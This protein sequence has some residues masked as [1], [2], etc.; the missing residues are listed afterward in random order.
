LQKAPEFLWRGLVGAV[1]AVT[2]LAGVG[3]VLLVLLTIWLVWANRTPREPWPPVLALFVGAPIFLFLIDIRRSGLGIDAAAAPRYS[4][5]VLA[6]L[7]PAA[8]LAATSLFA[9]RP[10]RVVLILGGTALLCVVGVSELNDQARIY[11]PFKQENE[12]RIIA[13]A[14]LVRSDATLLTNQPAPEFSPE[15]RVDSLR[16]L[17]RD[18]NLPDNVHV[19]EADRLTAASFLQVTVGT[20]PAANATGEPT[21]EGAE[22]ARVTSSNSGSCIVVTPR[23]DVPTVLLSFAEPGT[24]NVTPSRSGGITTALQPPDAQSSVHSGTRTWPAPGG[25]TRAVSSAATELWLR[26]GVPAEGTTRVCNL[27]N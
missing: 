1:D 11:T 14:D 7:A 13:A 5:A 23:S 12:R 17:Q 25:E 26:L 9:R 6:L 16:A 4:Y 27:S 8:A 24:I 3:P 19:D 10:F 2:G 20:E 18:G 22:G 21:I 15:L